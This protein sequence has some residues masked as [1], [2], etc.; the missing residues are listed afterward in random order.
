MKWIWGAMLLALAAWVPLAGATAAPAMTDAGALQGVSA[1]GLTIYKGVPYA[2]APVG[3][4]RW[5][6]PQPVQPWQ[7]VRQASAFAPACLQM[8]VSMPGESPPPASEDCLYL[9]V[10]TLAKSPRQRLPVMVWIPGGGF[11][12]GWSGMPLYWGDHLARKG[13]IL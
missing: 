5:R 10:W 13:V 9:N 1:G 8:G 6:E 3:E 4:L 11:I 7:G 12:A 2:A